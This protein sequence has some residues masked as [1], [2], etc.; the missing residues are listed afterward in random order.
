MICHCVSSKTHEQTCLIHLSFRYNE[1]GD[2]KDESEEGDK[3]V[4]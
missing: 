1:K 4:P 3:D 2:S